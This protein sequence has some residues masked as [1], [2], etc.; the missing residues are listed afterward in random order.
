VPAEEIQLA[1]GETPQPEAPWR[2]DGFAKDGKLRSS[3]GIPVY[4]K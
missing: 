3:Y 1:K 2:P 4:K